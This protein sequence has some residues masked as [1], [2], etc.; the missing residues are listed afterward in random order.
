MPALL[1]LAIQAFELTPVTFM[2][3][4]AWQNMLRMPFGTDMDQ[5]AYGVIKQVGIGRKMHV[6]F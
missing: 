5:G 3:P 6:R 4:P 1:Q 2:I